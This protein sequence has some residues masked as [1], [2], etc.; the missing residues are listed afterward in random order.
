M[1]VKF[2]FCAYFVICA[3]TFVITPAYAQEITILYTGDTHAALYPCN[4]PLEADGGISRRSALIKELKKEH[5]DTLVLDSGGFF[6]G[7]LLDEY[8]QNTELDQERTLINLR[9]M[10]AMG[11]DAAA[12]GEDEF[13]FGRQ[14][15]EENIPK[16]K[17]AFLSCNMQPAKVS[18]FM[19][20]ELSGVKIGIIGVTHTQA[21]Q[22]AGGIKFSGPGPALSG[23]IVALRKEGASIIILLSHLGEAEE[24]NLIGEIK[25]VDILISGRSQAQAKL[26]DMVDST[27]FL[28]PSW[29]GR[30]LGR[31]TFKV[32]NGKILEY[33]IE[34]LRLSDKVKDD[35]QIVAFL[36]VCFS[37]NNC[38]KEGLAGSCQN[39][40]KADARCLYNQPNKIN[41]TI[42]TSGD[43]LVCESKGFIDFLKK[44][45]PG[46]TTTYLYYAEAKVRKLAADL[47]IN[48]LPAYLLDRGIEKEKELGGFNKELEKKGDFYI[49]K[50]SFA[51]VSYFPQ[52]QRIK[53]RLDLFM[54]FYTKDITEV[55]EVIKEFQP[56]IHFLAQDNRD[57]FE[58]PGG[59]FEVEE[60][61]RALCVQKYYPSRFFGYVQCRAKNNNSSWWEDC[62]AGLD[63][64]VVKTCA[65][66][67]EAGELL[68]ENIKLNKELGIIVSPVYLIDNQQIFSTQGA[69]K[70]EDFQKLFNS[71][72]KK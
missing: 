19:M 42:I 47:G 5:P 68:K 8:T 27:I 23:A 56:D 26:P 51:G 34:A 67:N 6:A 18:P 66:S 9:A 50:P 14:F 10:E 71:L 58:A 17:L 33:K 36:P 59:N 65:K 29:Q 31:L 48:G 49:F 72:K 13:N 70:K 12:V 41:L 4:C 40:A 55:L 1:I 54:S 21:A 22:K 53:G 60:D 7:G 39:P 64:A 25:G 69:P 32:E 20:K 57:K 3:L 62:L 45:L 43:C 46:L 38:R 61:L 63:A 30:T 16:T 28:R 2:K 37:D 52:R 11:Y 35:P 15:F 44:R 24:L